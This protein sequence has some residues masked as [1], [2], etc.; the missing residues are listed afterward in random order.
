MK[1]STVVSE[2]T[3]LLSLILLIFAVSWL[4]FCAFIYLLM[5]KLCW[6]FVFFLYLVLIGVINVLNEHYKLKFLQVVTNVLFSPINVLKI[7]FNIA[8]PG[9]YITSSFINLII[10][11]FCIPV[12]I[13]KGVQMILGLDFCMATIIFI[14]FASGSILCVYLSPMIQR[15]ICWLPPFD[16][17]KHKYQK[18]GKDLSM[19]ILHP[20]NLLFILFFAYFLYLAISGFIQIQYKDYLI[21]KEIDGA[22]LKAFLVFI[23]YSN[24]VVKSRD[25]DIQAKDL[26]KKM[27]E[28]IITSDDKKIE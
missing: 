5:N 8:R 7:L 21:D 28:L 23:A 26:L 22:I 14:V 3:K 1:R 11:A 16:D 13:C 6:I 12:L 19:Y 25:V 18:L 20:K 17:L 24:M 9:I 2:R 27:L 4:V 10:V 15:I